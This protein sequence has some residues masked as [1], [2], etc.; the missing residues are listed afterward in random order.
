MNNLLK[1]ATGEL[2]VTEIGGET[3]N[4]RILQYAEDIGL[5]WINDDE[6]PWC[7]IF[8][9]WVALKAGVKQSESAAARSWLNVGFSVQKPEPGDIA[10]Y[11]RGNPESHKGHVGI[12]LGFSSDHDRIYTLG[13]NQNNSVSISAYPR[14]RLLDFRRLPNQEEISLP[15]RELKRGDIGQAVVAMQDALK[16]AGFDIGTSDG[17][18]GPKT[19]GGVKQLQ[20]TN[21]ELEI[22]GQFDAATRKYLME[23]LNT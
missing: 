10:V 12:F 23:L 4:E 5:S 21:F 3:H 8:M 6:T 20:A 11:W 16:I 9:N 19:E 7:S 1:I 14:E 22:S 15:D 13:G 18:Y 2:G 17:I